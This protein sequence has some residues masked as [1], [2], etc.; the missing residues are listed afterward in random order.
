MRVMLAIWLLVI[1][2][3]LAYFLIVGFSN[4]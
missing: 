4:A 1:G 3:G 2:G